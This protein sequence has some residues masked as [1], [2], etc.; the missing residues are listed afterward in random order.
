MVCSAP[1]ESKQMSETEEM[2]IARFERYFK[3]PD[4]NHE[5]LERGDRALACI[6][7]RRALH[8]LGISV[9]KQQSDHFDRTL[10]SGIKELQ[11]KFHHRIIDGRVGPGTR[12]LIVR[13]VLHI[14]DASIFQRLRKPELAPSVFI[15]YASADREKVDKIEQWLRDNGIHVMRDKTFFVPG[16]GISDNIRQAI[17][18]ADKVVAVFSANSRDSDWTTHERA[19]AEGLEDVIGKRLLI[20]L[21][22]DATPLPKHDRARL[23]ISAEDKTL[24]WVG[25][26]I[27]YTLNVRDLESKQVQ[28]KEDEVL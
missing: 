13:E 9:A 26:Q 18:A 1:L 16:E 24:K 2:L 21:C 28:Y 11:E 10:E 12:K 22:L 14:H 20:Y 6:N 25:D 5:V 27:L 23:A 3:H 4:V 17:A 15:S 7:L 19:L 8:L